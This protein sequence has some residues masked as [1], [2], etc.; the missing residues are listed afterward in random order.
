MTDEKLRDRGS[1]DAGFVERALDGL[2][3]EAITKAVAAGVRHV[4][5]TQEGVR[6]IAEGVPKE[7]V[8]FVREQLDGM[9]ADI[10]ELLSTEIRDFLDRVNL[11]QEIQRALTALTLQV[12]MEVRFK[13]SKDGSI[14]PSV[15]GTVKPKRSRG[16]KK[17]EAAP[18]DEA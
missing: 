3:G 2:R 6:K 1:E 18:A 16:R 4:L 8:G 13:P 17:A 10:F 5:A 11:G 14:R 12:T 9:R 7:I 15:K